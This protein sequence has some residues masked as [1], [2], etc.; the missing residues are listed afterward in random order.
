MLTCTP[1]PAKVFVTNSPAG[2]AAS[3]SP[4]PVTTPQGG[5]Y[6]TTLL[7]ITAG[8]GAA[9][10]IYTAQVSAT[11]AVGNTTYHSSIPLVINVSSRSG[12]QPGGNTYV[13]DCLRV[14]IRIDNNRNAVYPAILKSI[15]RTGDNVD[16]AGR[17]LSGQCRRARIHTPGRA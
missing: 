6:G 12:P 15:K 8:A 3:F 7:N 16:S 9:N 4:D 1:Y 10:G 14:V 17:L 2:V 13:Q 5:A 11:M